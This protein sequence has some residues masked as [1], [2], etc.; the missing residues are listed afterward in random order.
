MG[1]KGPA[2]DIG[3]VGELPHSDL[4]EVL[5]PHQRRQCVPQP[6][7]GTAHPPVLILLSWHI[8]IS[9]KI[10]PVFQRIF[11]TLSIIPQRSLCLPIE[12]FSI[13]IIIDI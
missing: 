6:L 12:S 1:V 5:L 7:F 9:H 2:V 13:F 10:F 11:G 4:P 8:F 3:Q